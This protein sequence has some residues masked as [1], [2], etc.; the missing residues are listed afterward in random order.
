[1]SWL[2]PEIRSWIYNICAAVIPLLITLGVL[3]QDVAG[4]VMIIV[5]AVLGVGSNVLARVNVPKTSADAGVI[6]ADAGVTDGQ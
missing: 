4:Q 2:T 6:N 3:S 5:A 1:V